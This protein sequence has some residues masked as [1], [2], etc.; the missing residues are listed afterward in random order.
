MWFLG[1]REAVHLRSAENWA[2]MSDF[3]S[4]LAF[5]INSYVIGCETIW[6]ATKN[7]LINTH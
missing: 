4:K 6:L 5:I 7:L 1:G 3:H 2:R